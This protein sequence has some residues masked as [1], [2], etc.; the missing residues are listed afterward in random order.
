LVLHIW[1]HLHS[2]VCS[3]RCKIK[4]TPTQHSAFYIKDEEKIS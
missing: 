3:P 1:S 2:H 4:L